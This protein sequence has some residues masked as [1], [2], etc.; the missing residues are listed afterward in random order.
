MNRIAKASDSF[1]GQKKVQDRRVFSLST[2]LNVYNAVLVIVLLS[3]M[4]NIKATR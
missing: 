2:M 4:Y 3:N 1:D